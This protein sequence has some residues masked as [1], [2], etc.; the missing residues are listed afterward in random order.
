MFDEINEGWLTISERSFRFGVFCDTWHDSN[1]TKTA[2]WNPSEVIRLCMLIQR[3]RIKGKTVC[4]PYKSDLSLTY[5][6]VIR[7]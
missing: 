7:V 5:I 4:R 6:S 2:A 3:I 1:A